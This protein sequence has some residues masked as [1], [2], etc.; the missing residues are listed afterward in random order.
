MYAANF[1]VLAR[2]WTVGFGRVSK[3]DL[4]VQECFKYVIRN[5]ERI[6][7]SSELSAE[8]MDALRKVTS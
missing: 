3:N 7:L 1:A 6:G 8:A 4:L 2:E 5:K